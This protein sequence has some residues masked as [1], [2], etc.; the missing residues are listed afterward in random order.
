LHGFTV[1]RDSPFRVALVV[2]G[3]AAQVERALKAPIA[4]F[5]RNGKMQRGPIVDPA[6]PGELA[7]SVQAILGLDDIDPFRPV[8]Q[9]GLCL[10]GPREGMRCA[11]D[12]ECTGSV[13]GP[14]KALAPA[15]SRP[16][17]TSPRCRRRVSPGLDRSIA[18]IARS[19]SS[20]A[21]W[22]PSRSASCRAC[23]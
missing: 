5:R 13:C 21:T 17:T 23:S 6:L 1:V 18:V 22:R 19:N 3:T 2:S 9:V 10:A 15:T 11:S 7:A 16:P 4:L 8:A 20:T 14:S 12:G